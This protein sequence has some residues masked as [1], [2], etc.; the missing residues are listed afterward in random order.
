MNSFIKNF[1]ALLF[2]TMVAGVARAELSS[3]Y[4]F[5]FGFASLDAKTV[6]TS[7]SVTGEIVIDVNYNL[8]LASC[9]CTF[10]IT[11]QEFLQSNQGS[12]AYTRIALGSR[13]YPFNTNSFR[14]ILDNKTDGRIWRA[15]PFV[16]IEL[17]TSSLS[18]SKA[19]ELGRFYNSFANDIAIRLGNEIPIGAGVILL[20]HIIGSTSLN[21]SSGSSSGSSTQ[22]SYTG[23]AILIGFRFSSFD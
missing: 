6:A 12:L 20:G 22:A 8:V 11:M 9:K 1:I 18:V 14:V 5:N 23:F 4:D 17:G 2:V 3:S 16:G 19:D 15:A 13:Y 7:T 21:S 10:T